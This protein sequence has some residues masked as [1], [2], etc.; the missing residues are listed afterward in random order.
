MSVPVKFTDRNTRIEDVKILFDLDGVHALPV[1]EDDGTI[2]GIITSTDLAR[3]GN[4]EEIVEDL[5]TDRVHIVLPNNRVQDAANL[6]V[7]NKIHHLVVMEK[8]EVVGMLSSMDIVRLYA[9]EHLS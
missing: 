7:K 5:M 3:R 1:L 8:G 4:D 2:S 6:M 9:V